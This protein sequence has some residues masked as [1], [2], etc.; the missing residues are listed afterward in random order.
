MQRREQ[1]ERGVQPGLKVRLLAPG[2][3]RLA[4]GIAGDAQVAARGVG[5]QFGRQPVGLGPAPAVGGDGADLE[6][7]VRFAQ[8]VGIEAVLRT[9]GAL[10]VGDQRVGLGEQGAEQPPCGGCSE[11]EPQRALAAL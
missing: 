6:M 1:A 10:D 8:R 5:G 2:L 7:R 3:D 11:V 9:A 4:L